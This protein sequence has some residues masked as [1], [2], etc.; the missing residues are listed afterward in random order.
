MCVINT[1]TLT[2]TLE[3]FGKN[4]NQYDFSGAALWQYCYEARL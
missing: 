1:L 3:T 2:F 4:S